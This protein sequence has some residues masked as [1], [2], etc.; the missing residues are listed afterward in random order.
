MLFPTN[1]GSHS[2][3]CEFKT[4]DYSILNYYAL[5]RRLHITD[6]DMIVSL[7]SYKILLLSLLQALIY[8]RLNIFRR[9]KH[10][11]QY[12]IH[13]IRHTTCTDKRS[14]AISQQMP[15]K[16]SM[17]PQCDCGH[18]FIA[19]FSCRRLISPLA[20]NCQL[21]PLSPGEPQNSVCQ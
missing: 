11:T 1:H 12:T 14:E 20:F 7:F 15:A 9:R 17:S 16:R 5:Q 4:S 6:F 2:L 13:D 19:W 10:Y 8:F 18:L 3:T 21:H